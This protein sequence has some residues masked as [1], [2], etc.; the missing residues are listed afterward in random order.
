MDAMSLIG[1]PVF[2]VDAGRKLGIVERLL[3]SIEEKRVIA[4]ALEALRDPALTT[5]ILVTRPV[6]GP[7]CAV[8]TRVVAVWIY[9]PR[10]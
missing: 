6:F 8:R 5:V 9:E 7:C 2:A 4:P 10:S 3:F 1:M